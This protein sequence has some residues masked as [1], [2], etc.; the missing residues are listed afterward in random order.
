[1]IVGVGIDLVEVARIERV[2][3]KFGERFL[4]R[5]L[6]REEADYCLSHRKPATFIAGRFAVKEAVSKAFGTGMGALLGW[7]D[8]EVRRKESGEPYVILHGRGEEL[9]AAR[10][11]NVVH[12]SISHT[13]VNAVA[14]AILEQL[15]TLTDA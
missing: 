7:H 6:L 14:V 2:Y 9:L 5:V 8:I 3:T 1:M 4:G 13:E 12:I 11:A 15:P 10:K